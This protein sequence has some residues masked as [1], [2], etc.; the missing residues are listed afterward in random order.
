MID[1][2]WSAVRVEIIEWDDANVEH[3]TRH[4]VSVQEIEQVIVNA[5]VIRRNSGEGRATSGSRPARTADGRS[6]SSPPMTP[7]DGGSGR[8]PR[9]RSDEQADETL[10]GA[11]RGG[12]R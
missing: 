5:T 1:A 6:L 3:A 2:D 12:A 11:Y 8:S 7:H 4:G 9:G 10:G